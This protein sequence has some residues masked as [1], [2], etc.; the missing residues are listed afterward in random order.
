M[1]DL[2][3]DALFRL[4]DKKHFRDIPARELVEEAGVCRESFYRTTSR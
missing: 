1:K 3:T 2:L 4:V